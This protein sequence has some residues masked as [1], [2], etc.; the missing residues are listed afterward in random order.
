MIPSPRFLIIPGSSV[1]RHG[2]IE[3]HVK[4]AIDYVEPDQGDELPGLDDVG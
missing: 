3:E 2:D 1:S 4:K